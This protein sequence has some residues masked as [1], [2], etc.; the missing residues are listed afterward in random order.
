[1]RLNIYSLMRIYM[2][3]E[4]ILFIIIIV[5]IIHI[6]IRHKESLKKRI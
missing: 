6:I 4:K 3:Q 1:M 5:L 2:K